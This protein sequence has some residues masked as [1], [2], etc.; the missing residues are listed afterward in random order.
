MQKAILACVVLAACVQV[1]E[2][3]ETSAFMQHGMAEAVQAAVADVRKAERSRGPMDISSTSGTTLGKPSTYTACIEYLKG[4]ANPRVWAATVATLSSRLPQFAQDAGVHV[5][6]R[7]SNSPYHFSM[8]YTD[9]RRY[10][11]VVVKV[12]EG[13]KRVN[14]AADES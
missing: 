9:G 14:V 11:H 12:D 6:L 1:R 10:G 7:Q 8:T 5:T 3:E 4:D 2:R 13:T